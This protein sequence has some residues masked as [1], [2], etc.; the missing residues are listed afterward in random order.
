M[1]TPQGWAV[2][3]DGQA[4]LP[5]WVTALPKPFLSPRAVTAAA[6]ASATVTPTS[7]GLVAPWMAQTCGCV[8]DRQASCSVSGL[9]ALEPEPTLHS[10]AWCLDCSHTA[11]LSCQTSL[12]VSKTKLLRIQEHN[13]RT[14]NQTWDPC[15]SRALCELA[16]DPARFHPESGSAEDILN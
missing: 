3:L 13:P 2:M 15:E 4:V 7:L 6:S 1:Q 16:L 14:L 5:P 10:A 11:S 8:P 9:C 12:T